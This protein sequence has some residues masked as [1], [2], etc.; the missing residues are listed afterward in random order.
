[1]SEF[2][3]GLYD[4]FLLRDVVGKAT[5]GFILLIVVW[6]SVYGDIRFP[7]H[8]D[9][10]IGVVV[11]GISFVA[12]IIIQWIGVKIGAIRLYVWEETRSRSTVQEASLSAYHNFLERTRNKPFVRIQRER[13]VVLKHIAG[14]FATL[15]IFILV[16]RLVFLIC[17]NQFLQKVDYLMLP[18]LALIIFILWKESH[19]FAN[20]QRIWEKLE[21]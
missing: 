5:P 13:F 14:N 6:N 3:E 4:R 11:F 20:E 7:F 21:Q 9:I 19:H 12:G 1:M 2:L 15:G 17:S 10:F 16:I 18:V 8:K